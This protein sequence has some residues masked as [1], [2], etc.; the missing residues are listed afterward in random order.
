MYV[1]EGNLKKRDVT[2]GKKSLRLEEWATFGVHENL[3]KRD[4][5]NAKKTHSQEEDLSNQEIQREGSLGF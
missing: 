2:R 4:L 1:G 3:E 5:R